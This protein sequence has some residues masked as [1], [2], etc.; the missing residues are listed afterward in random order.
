MYLG[1]S[2]VKLLG[3][4]YGGSKFDS[5]FAQPRT[6]AYEYEYEYG[7]RDTGYGIRDKE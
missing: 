2:V 3:C 4:V 6:P 5:R 7:I 1:C